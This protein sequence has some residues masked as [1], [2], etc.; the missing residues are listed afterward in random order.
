MTQQD[1]VVAVFPTHAA[2]DDAIKVLGKHGVDLK[3]LSIIGQGY[4]SEEHAI[5]FYSVGDRI[6]SWGTTGAF[7][8]GIWGLLLAPA[9][10]VIPG[11]GTVALAGPVV[12]ALVS[13][14]EGVV[15]GG[16]I[17]ALGAALAE[18]GVPK[19]DV[20]KYETAIRANE[21]VLLVQGTDDERTRVRAL[22]DGL[23]A[24]PAATPAAA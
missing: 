16:G 5:G 21:F 8:G 23:A 11:V 3:T 17:S 10:F 14:L 15:I 7:W 12:A 6:R 1:P 2:A 24:A 13:A 18:F 22:L 9:L 19:D 20:V 4:H